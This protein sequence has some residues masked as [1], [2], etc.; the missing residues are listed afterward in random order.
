MSVDFAN[1]S[2]AVSIAIAIAIHSEFT[3]RLVVANAFGQKVR[4]VSE[5]EK[6]KKSAKT[7]CKVNSKSKKQKE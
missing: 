2:I 3:A 7:V 4:E 1:V 6:R 5:K